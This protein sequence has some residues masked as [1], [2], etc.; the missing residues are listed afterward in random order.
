MYVDDGIILVNDPVD[1]DEFKANQAL[2]IES[3][4]DSEEIFVMTH[5]TL[6]VDVFIAGFNVFDDTTY[7]NA[8]LHKNKPVLT[9]H[10]T[11]FHLHS[12]YNVDNEGMCKAFSEFSVDELCMR[13]HNY[14][15]VDNAI[16]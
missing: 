2:K 3:K 8:R 15:I 5:I 14:A 10:N 9:P 6:I 1:K 11:I 16:T 12:N 7:F 13:H 4:E